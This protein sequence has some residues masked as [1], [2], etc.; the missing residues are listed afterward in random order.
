MGDLLSINDRN[1]IFSGIYE[2]DKSEKMLK[3]KLPPKRIGKT[4]QLK[5]KHI[6]Y[7][8]LFNFLSLIEIYCPRLRTLDITIDSININISQLQSPIPYQ[9]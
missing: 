4:G 6:N 9:C 1:K 7:T 3:Y 8:I 2:T 5:I